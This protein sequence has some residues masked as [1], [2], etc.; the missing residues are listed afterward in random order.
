M[1]LACLHVE[2]KELLVVQVDG[3]VKR[4]DGSEHLTIERGQNGK[5]HGVVGADVQ[6][7]R[8]IE[9]DRLAVCLVGIGIGEIEQS[10]DVPN[11]IGNA[12]I[13][14]RPSAGGRFNRF[15]LVLEVHDAGHR[16]VTF[17]RLCWCLLF[18][19]R[20]ENSCNAQDCHCNN[21]K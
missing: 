18:L 10:L 21:G 19:A 1:A 13:G 9:A 4:L 8:G 15:Q 16:F 11:G 12:H 17:G 5:Q 20:H 7:K 14:Y 6:I 3:L 2:D